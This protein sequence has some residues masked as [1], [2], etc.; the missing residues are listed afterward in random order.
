M[1]YY[2][3]IFHTTEFGAQG[4]GG[5]FSSVKTFVAAADKSA[6]A[7][8]LIEAGATVLDCDHEITVDCDEV[9]VC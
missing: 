6:R 5:K 4:F 1:K 8:R 7:R 2:V 9:W 3:I